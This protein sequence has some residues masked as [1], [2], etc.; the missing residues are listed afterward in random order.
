MLTE[1]IASTDSDYVTGALSVY[2]EALDTLDQLY[3]AANNATT[4]LSQS[5]S[6]GSTYLVVADATAFPPYGLLVMG[7]EILYYPSRTNSVFKN[8]IRGFVGSRQNVWPPGTVV[9]CAVT[10]E[11]HN[12][13]KDA[14]INIENNLG[15]VT[16]PAAISLNGILSSLETKFLAPKPLFRATPIKGVPPLT[17]TFQNFSSGDP[18]RF[19]WDFG[20]GSTSVDDS[21]VHTYQQE[22]V[23]TVILNMITSSGAQGVITK[24]NYIRVSLE[25]APAFYYVTPLAGTISTIFSFVD[26]TDGQVVSRYW[27]WDDGDNLTVADPDIHAATH[28][29]GQPGVY[30][31][32]LIVVFAD[33]SLDR[34]LL[35]Q[36][37]VVM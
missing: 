8:V 28:Q 6:Y 14:V 27:I 16:N 7:T 1:R 9:S 32:T 11:M 37:I 34:L 4:T 22:G 36:P 5:V 21:P 25:E 35:S 30:N 10:S 2:P 26:Q 33:Q 13:V 3:V 31:P 12:A 19:L 23:Y 18:I 20:D 17:V 29:Y 24:N 15:L